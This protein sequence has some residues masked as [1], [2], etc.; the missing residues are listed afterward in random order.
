MK[1][2]EV[3]FILAAG[4]GERLRP[5]TDTVPKPLLPVAGKP[6]LDHIFENLCSLSLKRVVLNAWHLKDQIIN[7]VHSRQKKFPFEFVVSEE[8][9]LLGT[10]GG[11]KKAY[12]FIQSSPFLMLNGDCLWSGDLKAFVETSPFTQ[13]DAVWWLA[14]R[15]EDQTKIYTNK[16]EIVGIGNLWGHTSSTASC[17]SGIQLM[18]NVDRAKLPEKGCIIRDYWIPRLQ[19]GG[20]I[21]GISEGLTS[22]TDI[23]NLKRYQ[24]L[25]T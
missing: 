7:Y 15:Q 4:R 19:E 21:K 23:G 14:P 16:T 22:W 17:F 6:L 9:E 13:D 24:S 2:P 1:L 25:D 12:S 18:K 5:L 8:D 11:L 20:H 10:G 3:A